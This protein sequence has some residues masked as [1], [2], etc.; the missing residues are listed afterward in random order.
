MRVNYPKLMNKVVFEELQLQIIRLSV[1]IKFYHFYHVHHENVISCHAKVVKQSLIGVFH[2][3]KLNN[4][5]M[6]DHVYEINM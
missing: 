2:N 4:F 6:S 3:L 5:Y 1:H